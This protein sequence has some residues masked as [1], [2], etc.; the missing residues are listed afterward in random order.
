MHLRVAD[1]ELLVQMAASP[2]IG[3]IDETRWVDGWLRTRDAATIDEQ[4]GLVT[5]LGRLDSQISIGG[6]KVDLT[7]VEQ[8]LCALP[9]VAAAVV[10][11]EG[12]IEAYLVLREGSARADVEAELSERL[13]SY[14]RPRRLNVVA[15][16]PRTATGKNV[17][18]RAVLRAAAQAQTAAPP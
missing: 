1:G 16:L 3:L 5:V 12:H 6:L 18:D 2:Y 9:Q 15:A 4:T 14:K 8:T 13:A 17:R 7:E 10:T 11:Y